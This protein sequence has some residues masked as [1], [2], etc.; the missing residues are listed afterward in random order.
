MLQDQFHVDN[1]FFKQEFSLMSAVFIIILS[2]RGERKKALSVRRL[3]W[4]CLV[5]HVN[6]ITCQKLHFCP[7]T[8]F[9][10]ILNILQFL[11]KY[12]FDKGL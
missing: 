1:I 7:Q 9:V 5:T 6:D 10:L 11:G 12:K 2:D 4:D 8:N 3:F